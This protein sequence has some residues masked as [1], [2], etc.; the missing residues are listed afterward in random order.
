MKILLTG[1]GTGGHFYPIIAVAEALRKY[2]DEK[3]LQ[4]FEL[5]YMAP[6]PYDKAMLDRLDIVFVPVA[7]GKMRRYFS[8]ANFFDLFKTGFGVLK[9]LFKIFMIYPDVVFGK[10]GYV[11]FPALFAASILRIPIVIH[12]SDSVPGRLN[13]WAGKIAARIAV[14]YPQAA[15]FFP[16]EKAANTGNPI[17]EEIAHISKEGAHAALG[18]DPNVPTILILGGSQGSQIINENLLNGLAQ[19]VEK[20]QV[21]HQAGENNFNYVQETAGVVL[22]DSKFK[23]RYKIYDHLNADILKKAAGAADL[24]VSR[25]GST[26]FEIALWGIPSILIPITDSNGDHQR[27]NAYN[28]ARTGAAVVIEENNLTSNV[29]VSEINRLMDDQ[30]LRN[31]MKEAAQ[32]FSHANAADLIAQEIIKLAL[33]HEK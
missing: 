14:S 9:A 25:A 26:I 7:T 5:Y 30:S 27:K 12:E 8:L 18:L 15:E 2:A 22:L 33:P 20:Y 10:G 24:V 17:R 13:M 29:L 4:N 16:R 31:H 6:E 3:Q 23:N 1:G 19:L 21:I 11:S 28:Y 32:G